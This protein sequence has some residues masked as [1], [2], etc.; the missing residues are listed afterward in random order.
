MDEDET[1]AS[2]RSDRKRAVSAAGQKGRFWRGQ[3]GN[4]KGRPPGARG[5]KLIVNDFAREL[6]WVMERGVRVRR[7]TLELVL[8]TIRNLALQGDRRAFIALH[9][10]SQRYEPE[11]AAESAWVSDRSGTRGRGS[12]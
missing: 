1:A 5:R 7:S 4:P 10:L 2:D 8:L 3:S 6:H 12:L 9:K 11:Q